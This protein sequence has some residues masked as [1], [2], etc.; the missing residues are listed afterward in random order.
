MCHKT[1]PTYQ[2]TICPFQPPTI[3]W[4]ASVQVWSPLFD[5]LPFWIAS[6]QTF[7]RDWIIY[8]PIPTNVEL[9]YIEKSIYTHIYIYI[10]IE[11]NSE[12]KKNFPIST[13]VEQQDECGIASTFFGFGPFPAWSGR[14]LFNISFVW[15]SPFCH[16]EDAILSQF[17]SWFVFSFHSLRLVNLS[18]L[19]NPDFLTIHL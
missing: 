15:M 1:Q 5:L 14:E 18:R 13:D 6:K 10:Y 7:L 9:T 12:K 2:P 8:K 17:L 11:K 19:K 4:H 3:W 16:W